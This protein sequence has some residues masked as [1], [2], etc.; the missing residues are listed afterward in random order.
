MNINIRPETAADHEAIRHVHR[1]AFGQDAEARLVDAL[2]DGGYVRT[3]LVAEKDGQVVGH[4]LFSDLPIITDAGTVPALALAPMAVL[5]GLQRQGIGS[6]LVRRGLVECRQ[7]GHQIVV[8]VGHPHFYPRFGF[9]S[10]LASALASP[11]GGGDSWMALELVP[12]ALDGVRGRVQYPSP[13]EQVPEVR[14][15]RNGDQAEWLRMRALLWPDGADGEHAQE[16]AAFFSNQTFSWSES[17]PA[18]AVFVAV[19]PSGG[20]CGFLEASIRPF[21]EGCKTRPVGYIEGWFVDPEMRQQGIGKSLV[22]AAEQW[23]TAQG[24]REMASDAHLENTASVMAHKALGFEESSRAVHLRKRLNV[25]SGKTRDRICAPRPLTLL[26]LDDTFAICRLG[27][28]APIPP[29]A[30]AG[31]LFSITRTADELSVVCPQEAIPEGLKCE[32]DWRC[33]RVAGTIAFSVVGVLAS[34]TAPLAEAGISV[35]ALSTFD[36]DYLLL[37]EKDLERAIDVLRRQGHTVQSGTERVLDAKGV[38]PHGILSKEGEG[39]RRP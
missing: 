20:L 22:T 34:L 25:A 4:I 3:S 1:L 38:P 16:V 14:T 39:K 12:G 8:V 17:L 33:L 23:A 19:R 26:V 30:T 37:K 18:V 6:A 5:P 32:R 21:A 10:K 35:F 24:C 28:D 11:F 13:F 31:N 36:T 7:Q 27:S 15:V 29:W 2:R 9:S